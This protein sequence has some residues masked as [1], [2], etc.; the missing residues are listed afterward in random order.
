MQVALVVLLI[1]NTPNVEKLMAN[2]VKCV[3]NGHQC[4]KKDVFVTCRAA[5][6]KEAQKKSEIT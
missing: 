4:S 3:V 6:L 2:M 1:N 5:L